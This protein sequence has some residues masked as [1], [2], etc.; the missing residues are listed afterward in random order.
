MTSGVLQNLPRHSSHAPLSGGAGLSQ[1]IV[2][3]I[4]ASVRQ[5]LLNRSKERGEDF[6]LTL[7]HFALERLMYRLSQPPYRDRFVLKGAMFFSVWSETPHRATRDLDLLGRDAH[8]VSALA[9]QFREFCA[10]SVEDDGLMFF[11]KSIVGEEFAKETSTKG[12]ACPSMR[13]L[14]SPAF[15][16]KSIS[17]LAM[18][19]SRNRSSLRTQRCL[20]SQR[21][22]S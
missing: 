14:A 16:S 20:N 17:D 6:Q 9:L 15:R 12:Y 1:K 4:A 7:I 3:D 21:L 8:E 5:R 11:P 19:C 18:R 13:A 2:K 22:G 10:T